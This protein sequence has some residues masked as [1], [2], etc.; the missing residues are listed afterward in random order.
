MSETNAPSYPTRKV[1]CFIKEA[2]NEQTSLPSL[3]PLELEGRARV[4]LRVKHAAV[5]APRFA[6]H[7]GAKVALLHTHSAH[8]KHK[9]HDVEWQLDSHC[10]QHRGDWPAGVYS[11]AMV[12]EVHGCGGGVQD[13][14]VLPKG[15]EVHDIAWKSTSAAQSL[16]TRV[17]SL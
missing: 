5:V 7:F 16:N 2:S 1:V 10:V 17:D 3:E 12:K 9:G 13:D 6:V 4:N 8:S 14:D 11:R 15:L